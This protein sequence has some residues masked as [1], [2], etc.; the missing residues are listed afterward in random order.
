MLDGHLSRHRVAGGSLH[1]RSRLHP[2]LWVQGHDGEP[3]LFAEPGGLG[4]I[5]VRERQEKKF[6]LVLDERCVKM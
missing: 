3:G 2:G 6:F 5:R 1:V 4:N